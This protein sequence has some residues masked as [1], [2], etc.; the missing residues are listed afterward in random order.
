MRS[1]VSVVCALAALARAGEAGEEDPEIPVTEIQWLRS[2]YE[3]TGGPTW[4]NRDGWEKAAAAGWAPEAVKPCPPD[5]TTGGWLGIK[6]QGQNSDPKPWNILVIDLAIGADPR[7]PVCSGNNL[8]GYLPRSFA[9]VP[10]LNTFKVSGPVTACVGSGAGTKC[11]P[12]GL[13]D[14]EC[15]PEIGQLSGHMPIFLPDQ[16][17]V[18]GVYDT[19]ISGPLPLLS[20]SGSK[21]LAN[22]LLRNNRLTGVVPWGAIPESLRQLQLDENRDLHGTL[23]ERLF[24]ASQLQELSLQHLHGLSGTLPRLPSTMTTVRLDFNGITSFPDYLDTLTGLAHLSLAGRDRKGGRSFNLPSA[25]HKMVSLEELKLSAG[26]WGGTIPAELGNLRSVQVLEL[27]DN[28]LIGTIPMELCDL[29]ALKKLMLSNNLL[30]GSIPSCVGKLTNLDQLWLN[31]ND[32]SGSIPDLGALTLLTELP[33]NN[34]LLTGTVPMTLR[35]LTKLTGLT[36]NDNKL[37]I[38]GNKMNE[39]LDDLVDLTSVSLSRNSEIRSL[40]S[41]AI[42][43]LPKL[44]EFRCSHKRGGGS[45]SMQL[46]LEIPP[47]LKILDLAGND[48]STST[49]RI[50]D[51]WFPDTNGQG[52]EYLDLSGCGLTDGFDTPSGHKSFFGSLKDSLD[53]LRLSNNQLTAVPT[54]LWRVSLR[55]LDLSH[56]QIDGSMNTVLKDIA[57]GRQRPQGESA[58]FDVSTL[59]ILDLSFN[60]ITD[61]F[62][63]NVFASNWG[64]MRL[65]VLDVS[66]NQ[67]S[68]PFPPIFTALPTYSI[69]ASNNQLDGYLPN[70]LG[71]LQETLR[72]LDV[73]G[74]PDMRECQRNECAAEHLRTHKGT[75]I[76]D[77]AKSRCFQVSAVRLPATTLT[78]DATY[79][80]ASNCVCKDDYIG[81]EGDCVSCSKFIN[82]DGLNLLDCRS[83][84]DTDGTRLRNGFF[85]VWCSSEDSW[86]QV[87]QKSFNCSERLERLERDSHSPIAL[88]RC[89]VVARDHNPCQSESSQDGFSV[90]HEWKRAKGSCAIGYTGPACLECDSPAFAR[91]LG[92][93]ICQECNAWSPWVPL[94]YLIGIAGFVV[95]LATKN[96]SPSNLGGSFVFYFQ[97]ITLIKRSVLPWKQSNWETVLSSSFNMNPAMSGCVWYLQ[98][99]IEHAEQR[100]WFTMAVP[101]YVLLLFALVFLAGKSYDCY[102]DSH[103]DDKPTPAP[104][105]EPEPE[106]VAGGPQIEVSDQANTAAVDT[107]SKRTTVRG[108]NYEKTRSGELAPLL[109][110]DRAYKVLFSLANL[111]YLPLCFQSIA[112]NQLA[113]VEFEFIPDDSS[114]SGR[115]LLNAPEVIVPETLFATSDASPF[116]WTAA[117]RMTIGSW[118]GVV[119]YVVGI[120]AAIWFGVYVRIREIDQKRIDSIKQEK[121]PLKKYETDKEWLDSMPAAQLRDTVKVIDNAVLDEITRLQDLEKNPSKDPNRMIRIG[122][123]HFCAFKQEY[124][125][126]PFAV[127]VRKVFF[128]WAIAYFPPNDPLLPVLV[129]L[130]LLVALLC[131]VASR[132]LVGYWDNILEELTLVVL[133]V[134]F[135][136]A[137]VVMAD[138][139]TSRSSETELEH[140]TA[141]A[142]WFD[143][144]IVALFAI[145]ILLRK[146]LQEDSGILGCGKCTTWFAGTRLGRTLTESS[147]IRSVTTILTIGEEEARER[148]SMR[149]GADRLH[150]DGGQRPPVVQPPPHVRG[151]AAAVAVAQSNSQLEASHNVARLGASRPASPGGRAFG[152]AE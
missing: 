117:A 119:V 93:R 131:Q 111:A 86:S 2:F 108:E 37:T 45:R 97:A 90:L 4:V 70:S 69:D 144:F 15:L 8:T 137:Q 68:G 44:I 40:P 61:R 55:T 24:V 132:P 95:W 28:A 98:W 54:D 46:N 21:L 14:E 138:K 43:S 32:L 35:Y 49:T 74:N 6:C 146:N 75:S 109:A 67:L 96:M 125:W 50:P 36:L 58:S 17:V 30:S 65:S 120:P 11:N 78:V 56:N 53:V 99:A 134:C 41:V 133:L 3:S 1:T 29:A 10:K 88:V 147:F 106:P 42:K 47:S 116:P 5:G 82:D 149:Q 89:P 103:N 121:D 141:V 18:F 130:V 150:S 105:P 113:S 101:L 87:W 60:H 129:F 73:R 136:L 94:I 85:P 19:H 140:F 143:A 66:D 102:Y 122:G 123:A 151:A 72:V 84:N 76:I 77:G 91:E 104:T 139:S 38:D 62:P 7:I 107:G 124:R 80:A 13:P 59:E 115:Y 92:S 81:F 71:M 63:A 25:F 39:W 16:A 118:L 148:G 126:W 114:L 9:G 142:K 110:L 127:M 152:G 100:F 27:F 112:G 145:S 79:S 23:P 22:L 51:S 128:T 31:H 48:F 52:L 64:F 57:P 83:S 135:T 26:G 12:E 33:L 34:N 20:S